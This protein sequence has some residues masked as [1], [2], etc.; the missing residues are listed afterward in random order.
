[1]VR[2]THSI[3]GSFP[4]PNL[5]WRWLGVYHLR[6]RFATSNYLVNTSPKQENAYDH[7]DN[8]SLEIATKGGSR[9]E[10][11]AKERQD[12]PEYPYEFSQFKFRESRKVW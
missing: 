5:N 9:D 3:L 2:N 12:Y 6:N 11:K 7:S 8:I 1:M 10:N 4:I